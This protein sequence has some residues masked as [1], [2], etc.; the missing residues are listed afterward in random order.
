MFELDGY[1]E[2]FFCKG[3]S[4]LGITSHVIMS[5]DDDDEEPRRQIVSL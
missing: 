1:I 4:L 2:T 3:V 5:N